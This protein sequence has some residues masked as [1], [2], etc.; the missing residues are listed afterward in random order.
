MGGSAVGWSAKGGSPI[1]VAEGETL[2]SLSSRYGVPSAALLSANGLS[3]ASEVKSGMR[4]VVPV[5]HADG[6]G[7][8]SA[9]GEKSAKK[10]AE[11]VAD[12]ER[13]KS[14]RTKAKD[15]EKDKAVAKAEKP[16]DKAD[17][18]TSAKEDGG[19][20]AYAEPSKQA[21]VK[22]PA[23]DKA[24]TGNLESGA[25]AAK[26]PLT[27]AKADASGVEPEFRWPARGRIIQGFKAGGNDGI[28]ISVPAGTSVRAAESR[29]RRL[30]RR[31]AQGL[32]Q[33]GADQASQRLRHRLR[34]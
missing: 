33:P 20:V 30:L 3:S 2:D 19:A 1:V 4:M 12:A 29:R 8:A 23:I 31:R 32:R 16:G 34:Q 11:D 15:D 26:V 5:Y 24:P 10:R 18:P 25:E 13:A 9:E 7:V 21:D 17:K 28:N 22:A 6:H 27:G 14:I